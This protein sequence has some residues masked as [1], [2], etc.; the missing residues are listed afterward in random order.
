[1]SV[2]SPGDSNDRRRFSIRKILNKD[3][4][5]FQD[6]LGAHGLISAL[7]VNL[8]FRK[9]TTIYTDRDLFAVE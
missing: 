2:T 1:M 7:S 3:L 4:Q 8:M 6:F 5:Q 9:P